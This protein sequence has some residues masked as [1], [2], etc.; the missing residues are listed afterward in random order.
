MAA[1][2]AA[3]E[4]LNCAI[5]CELFDNAVSLNCGHS[6]C[7]QCIE[8]HWEKR[9]G[10]GYTCPLCM[11]A[12]REKPEL[13][14]NTVLCA[15][16]ERC[17]AG[18]G[19]AAAC[20]SEVCCSFCPSSPDSK[21]DR[22]CLTC[23]ASYCAVHLKPHLEVAALKEHL[24]VAPVE[25]TEKQCQLHG[26]MLAFHCKSDKGLL[27]SQCFA[28]HQECE[29]VSIEEELREKIESATQMK[30]LLKTKF[31]EL[32]TC[33]EKQGRAALRAV[34]HEE[35]ATQEK[36]SGII[37]QLADK[38]VELKKAK[39]HIEQLEHEDWQTLLKDDLT[40]FETDMDFSSAE[41]ITLDEHKMSNIKDAVAEL[42]KNI[43]ENESLK[44][45][46]H[47]E[48][49]VVENQV[50]P[51]HGMSANSE[52]TKT[53][54]RTTNFL[55]RTVKLTFDSSTANRYLRLERNNVTVTSQLHHPSDVN[56]FAVSQVMCLEGFSSGRHS[57]KVNTEK[58]GGWAIG[59]AYKPIDKAVYLGRNSRSWC[60]EYS[61]KRLSAWH[62]RCE[63]PL[64][65]PKPCTVIVE[66]DYIEGKLSFYSITET[67]TLLHTFEAVFT[68]SVFPAFWLYGL[69]KQNT[70]ILN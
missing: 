4:D 18:Q 67:A 51:V 58:S 5:C 6:F 65:H 56:R 19:Q 49:Y 16:A 26:G 61:N 62:S 29:I 59:I 68:Q 55:Q 14:K 22:T 34:E 57:W 30:A 40:E 43:L 11:K 60:L 23:R 20:G 3:A 21:A 13:N 44:L 42:R 28:L 50:S 46:V 1:F 7:R 31:T 37:N 35:R 2:S 63:I 70:L 54:L 53:P 45:T 36:I 27:C 66:L 8:Q 39:V 17:R 25:L 64:D 47:E 48:P 52:T 38:A 24:L 12:F 33:I 32:M 41:N 9:A 69:E 10:G 15:L